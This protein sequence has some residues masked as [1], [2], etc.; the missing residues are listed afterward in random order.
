M[1]AGKWKKQLK[2]ILY[3][4]VALAA[5]VLLWLIVALV[6]DVEMI[7]PRPD[8]A[9]RSFFLLF[10]KAKFWQAIG[11]TVLR[12]LIGFGISFALALGLAILARLWR[13]LARG[14]APL[15]TILRATPTMAIILLAIIWMSSAT[16]PLLI[17]FLVIFPQLYAAIYA[18]IT[19][20]DADVVEMSKVYRVSRRDMVTKL[21]IPYLVPALFSSAR[22]NIGLNVKL[23]IAA[24]ALA[25]TS[26]SIGNFMQLSRIYLDTASLLGWT[27]AAILLGAALE[28][29]VS[30]IRRLTVKWEAKE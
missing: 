20:T 8:V 23:M 6:T 18:A 26:L 4:M 29:M 9:M 5:F 7:L 28:G 16:A 14:L 21:Y 12:T 19:E 25:Q 24:E 17:T 15:I 27:I 3:P 2:N 22:S 1:S 10:A 30:L 11:M 13:P